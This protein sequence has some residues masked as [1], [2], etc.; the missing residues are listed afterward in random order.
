MSFFDKAQAAEGEANTRAGKNRKIKDG[1][2]RAIHKVLWS[3]DTR[4]RHLEGKL[5]SYFLSASDQVVVPAMIGANKIYD[6]QH[7]KGAAHPLGPRRTTL[8]A[9]FLKRVAEI[10]LAKVEGELAVFAKNC[11]EISVLTKTITIAEQKALLIKLLA[12]YT[13][14]QLLEQEIAA[15]L[16]FKC[17]KQDKDSKEDRYFFAIEVQQQS[18]LVHIFPLMRLML[19][20]AKAT[21]AD[22]PPP[23]GPL[24]RDIPRERR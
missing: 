23:S 19:K 15:C 16:F 6:G 17:K 18:F 9:G 12:S 20:G 13:T 24:I 2:E 21:L 4:L 22:G 11:D 10:D 3:L 7:V 5:P 14:P 1:G 8:A